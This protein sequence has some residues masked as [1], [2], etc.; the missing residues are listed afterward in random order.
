[1]LTVRD[2][3]PR[4]VEAITDI[5]NGYVSTSTATF[6]TQPIT[7]EE[8]RSRVADISE[9]FPY[10]V[11]EA[12]GVIAGYCYAH[13]WKERPAYLHTLETT[14]Y[15]SP[16]YVRQGI[17]TLLMRRLIDECAKRKYHALIACITAGNESSEILHR[18]LGFEQVSHFKQVG[19]KFGQWLGVV[20]YE[21]ILQ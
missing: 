2:V 19:R 11:C 17:G 18:K 7:V 15:L 21:L 20:D 1:M 16:S 5:H 3:Q 12:D 6:E 14:I 13:T 4:D 8:M 10:F 9:H